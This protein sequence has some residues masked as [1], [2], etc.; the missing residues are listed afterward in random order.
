M[1]I[2]PATPEDAAAIMRIWNPIIRDTAFTFT[3]ELKTEAGIAADIAARGAAFQ[4]CKRAGQV[5]GFATYSP[6]RGGPGYA[7]TKE[8]SIM[9]DA[10]AHGQGTGR[11][12]MAALEGQARAE[13][14]HSLW[15]GISGENAAAVGFHAALG[16]AHVARLPEVGFKFGRWMDLVLM[17]KIL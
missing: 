17:Q 14:V 12:L 15:A 1:M 5:V 2:R 11:A 4:V 8:H 9:L 7:H 10:Q 16:F 6:F 3:T 13:G